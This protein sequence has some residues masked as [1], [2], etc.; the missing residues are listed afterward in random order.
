MARVSKKFAANFEIWAADRMNPNSP[1]GHFSE[2]EMNEFKSML[3]K[4]LEPG[5][6]Q[7]REGVKI[8]IAHGVEVPAA[9][10]DHEE[11]YRLWD[12]FFAAEV[13]EITYRMRAAA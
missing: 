6:D 11:R 13:E 2:S 7:L 3:R 4:D 10:D 9:I 12:E 5:P 1:S 8:I